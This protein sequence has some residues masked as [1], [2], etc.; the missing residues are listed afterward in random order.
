MEM[1]KQT[2][3]PFIETVNLMMSVAKK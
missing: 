1:V 2:H 3:P